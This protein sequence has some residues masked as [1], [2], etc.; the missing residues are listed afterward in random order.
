MPAANILTTPT[1]PP[2]LAAL[3]AEVTPELR[4]AGYTPHAHHPLW[5]RDRDHGLATL[6]VSYAPDD[7]EGG[8]V[9]PFVGLVDERV[10]TLLATFKNSGPTHGLRHT[11]LVGATRYAPAPLDRQPVHSDAEVLEVA[12]ELLRWW[13]GAGPAFA[14]RF[15]DGLV[16]LDGLFNADHPEAGRYLTHELYRALRGIAV[17]RC[18]DPADDLLDVVAFHRARMQESGFWEVYGEQVRAFV[19]M[20]S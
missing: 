19:M 6:V 9:E 20:L 12:N 13:R 1:R 8:W 11:L 2:R 10:E 4:S 17:R 7:G 14:A 18:L 15:G 3:V 5:A 16:Q